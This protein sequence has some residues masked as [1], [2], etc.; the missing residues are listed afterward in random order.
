MSHKMSLFHS[1]W[2][3]LT[4]LSPSLLRRAGRGAIG[5]IRCNE[6]LCEHGQMEQINAR[7]RWETNLDEKCA[8]VCLCTCVGVTHI[9]RPGRTPLISSVFVWLC[10]FLD[11]MGVKNET[12]LKMTT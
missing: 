12:S 7:M 9:Y 2:E 1:S 6:H 5:S 4:S 11:A 10:L 8:P 3:V